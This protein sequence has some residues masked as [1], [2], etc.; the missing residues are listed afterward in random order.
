MIIG[1]IGIQEIV[2]DQIWKLC[3]KTLVEGVVITDGILRMGKSI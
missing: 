3:A 1:Y 2:I